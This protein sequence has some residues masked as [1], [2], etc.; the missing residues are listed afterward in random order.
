MT[1]RRSASREWPRLPGDPQNWITDRIAI[2][3]FEADVGAFDSVLTTSVFTTPFHRDRLVIDWPAQTLPQAP[4]ARW[5]A[6]VA[7][8]AALSNTVLVQDFAGLNRCGLLVSLALMAD[9]ASAQQAMAQVIARR[10][11][12]AMCSSTY[13][14]YLTADVRNQ[15]ERPS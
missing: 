10:G 13:Q 11:P 6:W 4:L 15:P 2:G 3:S 8:R 9:G 5:V 7:E 14:A 12:Y 1:A